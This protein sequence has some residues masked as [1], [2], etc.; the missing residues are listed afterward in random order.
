MLKP[1]R[2]HGRSELDLLENLRGTHLSSP[3]ASPPKDPQQ[4]PQLPACAMPPTS[5]PDDVAA[6]TPPVD[7]GDMKWTSQASVGHATMIAPS[8]DQAHPAEQSPHEQASTKANSGIGTSFPSTIGQTSSTPLAH[9]SIDGS[10]D[11]L[12]K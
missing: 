8:A 6:L 12:R 11:V 3:P 10:L 2:D 1:N 4:S 9:S 5:R 7:S